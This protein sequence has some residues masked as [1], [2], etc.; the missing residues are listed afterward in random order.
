[1]KPIKI[2]SDNSDK[3]TAALLAV[4][5]R[6]DAHTITQYREVDTAMLAAESA[7]EP[8]AKKHHTGAVLVYESAA[9]SPSY[10]RNAIGTRVN[11]AHD[12]EAL[13]GNLSDAMG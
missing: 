2:V 12:M 5:G 11:G 10:K 3:I 7:L 8:L 13:V 1:M 6:A 4:N 9:P